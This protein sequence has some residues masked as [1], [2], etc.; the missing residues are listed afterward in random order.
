MP[1]I[2]IVITCHY[3]SSLSIM[4]TIKIVITC[5]YPSSLSIMPTIKIVH[6]MAVIMSLSLLCD[7]HIATIFNTTQLGQSLRQP[8]HLP[9]RNKYSITIS[10]ESSAFCANSRVC[11]TSASPLTWVMMSF[12]CTM[13]LLSAGIYTYI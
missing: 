6:S 12:L 10:V 1:T 9:L 7:C 3:P 2:K 8:T 5:H 4:P 11:P 13:L